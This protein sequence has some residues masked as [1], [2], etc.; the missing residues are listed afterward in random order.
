MLHTLKWASLAFLAAFFVASATL[1]PFVY[2]GTAAAHAAAQPAVSSQAKAPL[3]VYFGDDN[4]GSFYAINAKTGALR[5]QKRPNTNYISWELAVVVNGIVYDCVLHSSRFGNGVVE[6]LN[7]SNGS[8]IWRD[9]L[10]GGT[11]CHRLAVANGMVYFIESYDRYKKN[12]R[13][14]QALN[15]SNGTVVWTALQQPT[16]R[17]GNPIV[18]NGILYFTE[19]DVNFDNS[20]LYALNAEN[21]S[22]IWVASLPHSASTDLNLV[23]GVIY[24]GIGNAVDALKASDGSII[25]STTTY[26]DTFQFAAPVVANGLLYYTVF[27]GYIVALN[28]KNGRVRWTYLVGNT[29]D[30]P[31]VVDNV[32]YVNTYTSTF[33]Y[34]LN[35]STGSLIW[36][37]NMGLPSTS[38]P[39]VAGNTFYTCLNF[40]ELSTL[41]VNTEKAKWTFPAPTNFLTVA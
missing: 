10:P 15:A 34:A 37:H 30:G 39:V 21:G 3:S 16:N 40:Q 25:W 24:A 13:N 11:Y 6:A 29:Y 32:V 41:N 33:I 9:A 20:H 14:V 1:F 17:F 27:Q 12:E 31:T 23:N 22:T 26:G 5:W 4:S 36:Q 38:N 8:V 2:P 18:V 19:H 28:A 35:A 7:A